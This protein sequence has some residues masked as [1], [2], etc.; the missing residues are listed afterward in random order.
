[1]RIPYVIDNQTYRLVDILNAI[2]KEHK[3][4]SLDVATAYFTV[5]GF[6]LIKDGLLQIGNLRLLLGAEPT[7]GEQIGLRPDAGIIKGLFRRDLEILPF[8][9]KT[10]QL[11]EDLIAYLRRDTVLVRLHDKGFLHAKCWLFYSDRPGQQMLF[12]RFRPILAIV[13]SSN[14]TTPG[15]TSNRELNLAH[16]VLIDPEEVEDSDATYAV[17]WLTDA[18]PSERITLENRQLLKS[19]VG[20]RAIIDLETWYERQWADA[21]DFKEELIEL[22]DA[23]KFGRKEY[24]PYQ[25]YMKALYEYFKDE[26]VAEIPTTTRSAVDLSEFQED[27]VK[28][29]RKILS[30]YDGVMIADSV[31]LGKTW[32]GKKLLEDFAYHLRQKALVICPASLR[33]MW[34]RELQDATISATV[35]SQ[36]ELGRQEF[37]PVPWGDADVTL[38]DESHNFRNQNAQRYASIEHLLG[39]NGGRGRDG[40]RKKVILLTATPIN[41]DLFDL[42][43]QLC[44][45]TRGDRSYFSACGIGDLYRYFLRAR[46]ES[47]KNTSAVVLFNLLEEIVIRRTR[48]F[49]RKAYPE[50]TIEGKRIHFPQR[51]LK[52]VNYDLETTYAGIYDDVVSGIESLKLAPYN[53]ENYKK[54]DVEV[55]EFEVG[56]EQALVGIFKSRYLK[57]F[58]SSIDAFRISIRRALSF[59]KTFESYILDGRLLKS[60]DFQK[61]LRYLA[62]EDEEDDA[63]PTSMVE[64][65]EADEEAK[66]V[67]EEIGTIDPS[68]YELRKL[69][70][71]VQHD[72]DV[73]TDIWHRIKDITSE[74]DAKLQ[75]LK[76]L[77]S[78]DLREE[79]VLIFSYYKDTARYLYRNL[80]HPDNP[81]AVKFCDQLGGVSMRRMDSGAD[82]KERL[83]IIQ[84]F[85]P[86]A[87]DKPEWKG[88]EKEINILISTDVLSEGQNLQDCGHLVNYDLHWNPTRMV[89]RAGRIDR[90]GTDFDTL[91]IYNMFPDV[92]LERLL[93]LVES[94]SKKIADIDRAGFLDTSVLGE[95][96]HPQ[97]FNTLRRIQDEDGSVIEEEEQFTELASNE[98]LM[99]QL[100][101]LIDLGGREMLESLPNGIH[102]GLVKS[103]AK[104]VFFYFK[105]PASEGGTHHFWKYF[106]L[107]DQRIIDNRYIVANTIACDR[108]TPRVVDPEMFRAVFDL[109]EKVIEEIIRSFQEQRA[110]ESAP[111]SV[112]PIQQTVA[113]V[114]QG[115][116]NHPDVDRR[117]AIETI[118]F[119]NQ[120]MLAIQVRDLRR[121][122]KEFQREGNI[123]TLLATID[124]LRNKFG[125]QQTASGNGKPGPL[126]KINRG[127]LRLICFDLVTGG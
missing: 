58:E 109:Q 74:K 50:A 92:G 49:I 15:L 45:V 4:R 7:S 119:L 97:N 5:G 103:G 22:L 104:G 107:K 34:E 111:R 85:A 67:L 95:T 83:R 54:A 43:N 78:K 113:T 127:D 55:D 81:K 40:G 46:Q 90:I 27:A 26:L 53:L 44:L 31:G 1:M 88:T 11:V 12:D 25:V 63:T 98:F 100:R 56:R 13:G 47:R 86:K 37:D 96:V 112:D 30:R 101:T 82:P 10:L 124:D 116:L 51:R 93:G 114:L 84:A 48:P 70:E 33:D 41:N 122:Y 108:D 99:Q 126:D 2:L 94:L 62:R 76:D 91:W 125:A 120:P 79:K 117:H 102:S 3:G 115:Y 69:H 123:K 71:A 72:V 19:E 36:E 57:R 18:K 20:A 65:I 6:G 110:L 77:L 52:T 59:L 17:S 80:G 61:V 73:L 105:A 39:A 87:N 121:A 75:R 64:E 60:T 66:Q 23:S 89:Q 42:Y 28:K 14:F 68:N 38:I 32:I 16:K 24:T 8:D 106:D 35:L 21:R 118:R 29:A 9:E